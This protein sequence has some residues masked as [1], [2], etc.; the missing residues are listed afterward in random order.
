[1]YDKLNEIENLLKS[2]NVNEA[3]NKLSILKE[4]I[5]PNINTTNNTNEG[6]DYTNK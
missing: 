6:N 1:M 2:N 4:E 3:L 5:K